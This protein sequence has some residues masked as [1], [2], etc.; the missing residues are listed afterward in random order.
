MRKGTSTL[1]RFV[2]LGH[3]QKAEAPIPLDDLA[4]AG[5]WDVLTRSVAAALLLSNGIRRDSEIYLVLLKANPVR[6]ILIKGAEVRNLSPD[7]RSIQGLLTKALATKPV[8][9]HP[10]ESS[11]GIYATHWDLGAVLD[12]CK[13]DGPI[14]LLHEMGLLL[15]SGRDVDPLRE[16]TFVLSDHEE[17]SPDQ[18]ALIRGRATA[19]HS[20][21]P[22]SLHTSSCI[23]IIHNLIDRAPPTGVR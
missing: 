7:D 2:I 14:V 3:T 4:G 17:F 6:T 16:G 13:T 22:L 5:R 19:M 23:A 8:A 21:G 10:A 20:L 15:E 9:Q 18:L 1:R 11:P 12:R